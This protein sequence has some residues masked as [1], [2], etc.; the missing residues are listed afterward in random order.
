[1]QKVQ[2][3]DYRIWISRF[4]GLQPTMRVTSF[5]VQGSMF[6]WK[7]NLLVRLML[8]YLQEFPT[9]KFISSFMKNIE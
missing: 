3:L 1:M 4:G 7:Y 6:S 9:I 8:R 5:C 2:H